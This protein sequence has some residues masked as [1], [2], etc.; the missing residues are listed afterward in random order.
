MKGR[1][2]LVTGAARGIG[3]ACARHLG[4]SGHALHII[5]LDVGE[6]E[7]AAQELRREGFGVD[8]HA[9]DV[10]AAGGAAAAVTAVAERSSG[11]LDVVV[12]NAFSYLRGGQISASSDEQFGHDMSALAGSYLAMVRE[13][14]NLL[15]AAPAGAVINL[16]SVRA[17]FA[18]GGFGSYS[19]AKAAVV[20][21][22]R[23]LAVELGPHG[24]RVNAVAP[25]IIGTSR[26]LELDPGSLDQLAAATPLR[27]IGTPDDVGG[28][29]AFLASPLASYIT[30]QVVTIDGGLTLPL[31]I[32]T[33]ADVIAHRDR[34]EERRA[35]RG[36]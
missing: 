11:R 23:Q 20:Q 30:G 31:H 22:T 17:R 12:N 4:R 7:A 16:A 10:F 5:D 34:G 19:V 36:T 29:V 8:V 33:V 28:V 15:L 21:L 32:D 6:G 2:A 3:L 13:S 1:V 18:G 14:R 26:T 27:R 25:G 24:V 9:V 35:D